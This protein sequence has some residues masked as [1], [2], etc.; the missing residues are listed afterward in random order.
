[1][2][3]S[4]VLS[5]MRGAR[6]MSSVSLSMNRYSRGIVVRRLNP[7]GSSLRT[8]FAISTE[9]TSVESP[10]DVSLTRQCRSWIPGTGFR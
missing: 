1:M 10:P 2:T 4:A 3:S 9:S 6:S 8:M 7:S 5:E